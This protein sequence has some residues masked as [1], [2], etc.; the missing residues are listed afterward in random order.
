MSVYLT[1]Y[2]LSS[3]FCFVLVVET[4]RKSDALSEV[5]LIAYIVIYTNIIL[6]S[7]Q[8]DNYLIL[9]LNVAN[10]GFAK[11]SLRVKSPMGILKSWHVC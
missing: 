5:V 1:I 6:N 3:L 8:K 7:L 10:L 11:T 2:F 9:R 4:H